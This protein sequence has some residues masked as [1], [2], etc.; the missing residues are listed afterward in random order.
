MSYNMSVCIFGSEWSFSLIKY[1]NIETHEA[2]SESPSHHPLPT[3]IPLEK[4]LSPLLK[5]W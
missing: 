2:K 1:V 5:G 4:P 3:L